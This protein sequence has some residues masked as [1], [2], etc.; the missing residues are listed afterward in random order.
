M[1]FRLLSMYFLWCIAVAQ[2]VVAQVVSEDFNHNQVNVSETNCWEFDDVS[3]SST[4]SIN[5]GANAPQAVADINGFLEDAEL[6]SPFIQFTGTGAIRFNHKMARDEWYYGYSNLTVYIR[7][8]NGNDVSI[9][10]H[11]YRVLGTTPNGLPTA[12]KSENIAVTW[13]GYYQVVWAWSAVSSYTVALLDDITMPH[14]TTTAVEYDTV[15]AG[16]ANVVYQPVNSTG[17]GNFSYQW[18]FRGAAGGSI[19][20]QTGNNRR[21]EIDWVNTSGDYVLRSVETYNTNCDG[22][23]TDFYVH[24]LARPTVTADISDTVC[25]G[26]AF[27]VTIRFSG[28]GPWELIYQIDGSMQQTLNTGLSTT[29]INIPAGSSFVDLL[30]IN[31]ASCAGTIIGLATLAPTYFTNPSTGP[32]YH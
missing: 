3:I 17:A 12:V 4:S 23:K 7:D 30:S 14:D 1:I 25:E 22:R 2:P 28:T 29:A 9:F 20:T 32:I 21:A 26:D 6:A 18:A 15:C 27:V 8:V 13:T 5:S 10:N 16:E 31:D 19:T 24:V 11:T